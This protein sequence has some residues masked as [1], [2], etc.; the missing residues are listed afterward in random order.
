MSTKTKTMIHR[1]LKKYQHKIANSQNESKNKYY[2]DKIIRYKKILGGKNYELMQPIK[3]LTFNSNVDFNTNPIIANGFGQLRHNKQLKSVIFERRSPYSTDVVIK[4]LY[5][6]VCHSDWHY[7]NGE[8]D[9]RVPLIPGHEICG[10]IVCLGSSVNKFHIGDYVL[11]GT[12]VNSCRVCTKC[13]MNLEQYCENG[14]SSTYDSFDRLPDE[15]IAS[16]EHTYGGFSTVITVNENYVFPLPKNIDLKCSA[17]LVCAGITVYSALKQ[18]N[19]KKGQTVA[20]AGIGGLG[21]MAIKI[22]KAMGASVIALTTTEWKLYDAK[23][24]GADATVLISN[25]NTMNEYMGKINYILDTIPYQHDINFYL[26]LLAFYGKICIIGLFDVVGVDNN[27]LAGSKLSI[28][29]SIVGGI[30]ETKEMLDF[31]NDHQIQP[32]VELISIFDIN[33]TYKKLINSNVKYRYVIDF[34]I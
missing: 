2:L 8:W 1:K 17:P 16:G 9:S 15:V 7:I 32:D 26:D 30:K 31:C 25:K 6:G 19:I 24:I 29:S 3:T 13:K 23:R 34:N 12:L 33:E 27:K 11:V 28:T 5:C 14:V 18:M 4:I 21:H 20:I 10:Q 22:A